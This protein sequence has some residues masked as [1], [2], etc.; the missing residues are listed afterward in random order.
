MEK[1]AKNCQHCGKFF[2]KDIT[3]SKKS[4]EF[5]KFCSR[6]CSNKGRVYVKE[7]YRFPERHVPWNKNR[8]VRTNTG[9]THIKKGEHRSIS[10]EF[11][12]KPPWN[13]GKKNP[14]FT[15][16]N[17]PKWK[18]GVTPKNEMI[19]NSPEMYA[20]RQ[21]VFGRDNFTCQFC[22]VRGGNLNDDHIKPFATHEDLRFSIDNGRTL[23]VNCH[24]KTKTFGVN[25]IRYSLTP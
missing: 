25:F 22:G 11:G 6:F 15:G 20:W 7:R 21:A 12:N 1:P 19:R 14:Y 5:V 16:P 18:G 3:C 24:R 8:H 4:W 10:T 2:E 17:N 23:C 9:K 13:K